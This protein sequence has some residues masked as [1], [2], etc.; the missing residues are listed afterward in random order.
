MKLVAYLR[1]STATQDLGLEVQRDGVQAYAKLYG[2]ELVQVL[3]EK[4][5]AKNLNRPQ[6]QIAL[7]MIADGAVDGII[8]YKLD[9]LSR[10]VSDLS[11][12]VDGPLSGASLISVNE[13][14]DT[15]SANGRLMLNILSSFSQ[16][17]REVLS[18]RTSQAL[19]A[20]KKKGVKLGRPRHTSKRRHARRLRNEG[21]T[22]RYI[23]EVIAKKEGRSKPYTPA[24]IRNMLNR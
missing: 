24:A 7:E 20:L 1:T 5:S 17:E 2:H 3:V 18:E 9:R 22:F 4:Q 19:Q 14:L 15:S 13:Q 11:K 10:S 23:G 16:H 12:L 6:L 21:K 8:I